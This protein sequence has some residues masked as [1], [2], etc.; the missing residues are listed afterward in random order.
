M[1]YIT[2]TDETNGAIHFCKKFPDEFE[3][4]RQKIIEDDASNLVKDKNLSF[5]SLNSNSGD[6]IFF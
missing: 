6:I 3:K 5:Y 1:I 2:K 4:L